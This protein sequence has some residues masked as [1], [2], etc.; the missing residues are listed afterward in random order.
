MTLVAKAD[1]MRD[2]GDRQLALAQQALGAINPPLDNV[3]VRRKTR[4]L[5]ECVREMARAHRQ[6]F[7]YAIERQVFAQIVFDE[8]GRSPQFVDRQ[9]VRVVND[10]SARYAIVA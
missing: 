2:F 6:R 7:R 4:R 5:L 3:M 10:G 9:T 8:L 1:A